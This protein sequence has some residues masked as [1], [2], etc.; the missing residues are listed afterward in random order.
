MRW[1]DKLCAVGAALTLAAC[2]GTENTVEDAML[3]ADVAA[4]AAEAAAQDVEV[5]HGPGG[6]MGFGLHAD[7]RLFGC[8]GGSRHGLTVVR[9]C[10]FKDVDGNEQD[11]YD[12]QA[13]ASIAVHT[14]IS[15][16]FS[17]DAHSASIN[18]TTDLLVSGLEGTETTRTW[19]GTG[20]G[21]A[22]RVRESDDG[23]VRQYDMT[24]SGEIKDVIIPV[25]R[26]EDGWPLSGTI[27]RTV[28]I[29]FT[30]G[31]RDGETVTRAATIEFNGTATVTVTV[32]GESYD[33]D[34]RTRGRPHRRD[35]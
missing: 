14:E 24:F 20:S 9:S 2:S 29:T 28:T 22:S 16:E 19:N 1:T 18:R 33:F 12:E 4:V 30:G 26:T 11:G 34:L 17:R 7:F 6:V 27:T 13:T 23:E 35:R 3:T 25:P 31:P 15:G 32:N 5:M 8:D 10:V 21:S